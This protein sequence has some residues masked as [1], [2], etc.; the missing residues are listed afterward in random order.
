MLEDVSLK[1]S[2]NFIKKVVELMKV[3]ERMMDNYEL[4]RLNRKC[5]MLA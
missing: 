5:L 2:S 1:I 3:G 4:R